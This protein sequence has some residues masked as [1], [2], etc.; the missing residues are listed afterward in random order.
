MIHW[1]TKAYLSLYDLKNLTTICLDKIE[2]LLQEI[3]ADED[4]KI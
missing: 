4:C 1:E 3:K 2:T